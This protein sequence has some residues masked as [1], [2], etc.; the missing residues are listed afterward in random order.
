[1]SYDFAQLN[2]KE[3]QGLGIDLISTVFKKRIERLN[4]EDRGVD[5]R[6]L[7]LRVRNIFQL[8]II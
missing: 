6:F 7:F 4:R 5:G 1:M 3:F 2:D 8:N